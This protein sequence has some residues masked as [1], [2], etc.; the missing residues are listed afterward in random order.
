VLPGGTASYTVALGPTHG[1]TFP[2]PVTLSVSGLPPGATATIS[3]QLVPAGTPL[4]NI[5]L[6]VQ[7]PQPTASLP[8]HA[9][10]HRGAP[11]ALWCV[12]LL[13]FSRKLRR[14]LGLLLLLAAGLAATL[15]L[16]G[17]GS[18]NGFFGQQEGTYTVT[19]TATAGAVS[20][21]TNVMLTVE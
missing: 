11:P 18:G 4:T 6:S 5:T 21:S 16:N 7:L 19:L 3:P 1:V 15:I 14:K 8:P 17:C 10:P 20:H 9:P 13:P 2:V 12:L